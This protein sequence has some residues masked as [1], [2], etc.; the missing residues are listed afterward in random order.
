MA[1]MQVLARIEGARFE[2]FSPE[3]FAF[4][5]KLARNNRREWFAT[6]KTLYE[7]TLMAPMLLLVEE[8][9]QQLHAKALPLAPPPRAPVQRIYRDIRFSPN[10]SPFKTNISSALYRDGNKKV[11]GALYLHLDAEQPF[12]AAGFW[13]PEKTSLRRWRDAIAADAKPLLQLAKKLPL[14][15]ADTLQRMPRG[16]ERFAD[17]PGA[18]LLRLKSFVVRR[19]LPQE[20]LFSRAILKTL[21][22]FAKQAEPLLRYG[23]SLEGA[24]D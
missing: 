1:T 20:E 9:A 3:A 24:A 16:Y 13:Q 21:L 12:V 14:D 5:R 10:K 8:F 17:R 11:D 22:Q 18:E 15:P 6:R 19:D 4:F 2:G 23:W 7:D